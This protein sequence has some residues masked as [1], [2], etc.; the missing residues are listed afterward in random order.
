MGVPY[1]VC[2]GQ[3][4][5]WFLSIFNFGPRDLTKVSGFYG[6]HFAHKVISPALHFYLIRIFFT[7]QEDWVT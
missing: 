7:K 6:K 1:Y 4:I 5:I 2:G 3:R